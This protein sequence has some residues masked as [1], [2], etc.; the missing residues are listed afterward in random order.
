MNVIS[1][2]LLPAF[3][4]VSLV[5][6][7]PRAWSQSSSGS[8]ARIAVDSADDPQLVKELRELLKS[9]IPSARVVNGDS[10]PYGSPAFLVEVPASTIDT[11]LT[12]I[13]SLGRGS[14]MPLNTLF[15]AYKFNAY[16]NPGRPTANLANESDIAQLARL[17]QEGHVLYKFSSAGA[18]I[19]A[20]HDLDKK[21]MSGLSEKTRDQVTQAL[22]SFQHKLRALFDGLDQE[23]DYAARDR[24]VSEAEAAG[25]KLSFDYVDITARNAVRQE[26]AAASDAGRLRT[27]LGDI[28]MA[29][30]RLDTPLS[31]SASLQ[32]IREGD[33]IELQI[34]HR[35]SAIRRKLFSQDLAL[36]L[37]AARMTVASLESGEGSDH[38]KSYVIRKGGG[39]ETGG[40][41]NSIFVMP[42]N[43]SSVTGRVIQWQHEFGSLAMLGDFSGESP[44]VK[45]I[46]NVILE[47]G[48]SLT[49]R[50]K[51]ANDIEIEK[52]ARKEAQATVNSIK[53]AN[54]NESHEIFEQVYQQVLA[55]GRKFE[56]LTTIYPL[57][58]FLE[59]LAYP[60]DQY[61]SPEYFSRRV[62]VSAKILESVLSKAK[63]EGLWKHTVDAANSLAK[64]GSYGFERVSTPAD[65]A[66]FEAFKQRTQKLFDDTKTGAHFGALCRNQFN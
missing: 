17:I 27:A 56:T 18:L 43:S 1:K 51:A 60:F 58:L 14:A 29:F 47:V 5:S 65:K 46:T 9:E 33:E 28:F 7:S 64:Y 52:R 19:K 61:F 53:P 59:R 41:R 16:E 49:E 35:S 15:K 24:I 34:A 63:S 11:A 31:L 37:N 48:D 13:R 22:M 26:R 32:T 36:V 38:S 3:A 25:R 20:V 39:F 10:I 55:S 4:I 50:A 12:K 6:V 45:Q 42:K 2:S 8:I 62:L 23:A 57:D 40:A 21:D 66:E 54:S 30:Q 44:L